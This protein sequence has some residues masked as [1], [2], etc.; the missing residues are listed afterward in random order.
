MKRISMS[1]VALLL[2]G[3]MGEAEQTTKIRD[4]KVDRLFTHDGCTVYRFSDNGFFRYFTNCT[5]SV[6]WSNKDHK[7]EIQTGGRNEALN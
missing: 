3:C 6:S 2:T 7:E 5:G 1:V 4:F